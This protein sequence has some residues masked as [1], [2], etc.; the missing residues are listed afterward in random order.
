MVG[1]TTLP[2]RGSSAP[3]HVTASDVS[4]FSKFPVTVTA[5]L[6]AGGTFKVDGT[7]GPVDEADTALTP[8]NA[9]LNV[10]GLNLAST[11]FLDSSAGLRGIV[12]LDGNLSSQGGQAQTKGSVT[13]SKALLVAG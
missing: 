10:T 13:L 8:L 7:F 11:G 1:W 4:L 9:K 3:V 2:T 12:D 6:P 5:D